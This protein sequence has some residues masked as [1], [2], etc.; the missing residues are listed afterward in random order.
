ME[1][2]CEQNIKE[3]LVFDISLK[4]PYVNRSD[5]CHDNRHKGLDNSE[6]FQINSYMIHLL[7]VCCKYEIRCR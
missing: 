2:F 3:N 1:A 7:K 5:D 4:P 6:L